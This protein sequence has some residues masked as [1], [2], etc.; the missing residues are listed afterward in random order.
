ARRPMRN[1]R[2]SPGRS[3]RRHADRHLEA[4][5]LL[6]G[7][8]ERLEVA[9]PERVQRRVGGE[10]GGRRLA[11]QAARGA[12]GHAEDLAQRVLAGSHGDRDR[13]DVVVDGQVLPPDTE[14]DGAARVTTSAAPLLTVAQPPDSSATP[15]P[16]RWLRSRPTTRP[17]S[18][19]L[20]F[21]P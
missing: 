21:L 6:D 15:P 12:D 3:F 4:E 10:L 13:A 17:S 11:A 9:D 7:P 19:S 1:A 18:V 2:R 16:L 8:V 14:C 20:T 5:V